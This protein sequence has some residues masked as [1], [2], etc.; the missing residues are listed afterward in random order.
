[1]NAE[2]LTAL[3]SNCTDP[4]IDER[5]DGNLLLQMSYNT[6][7][8]K[9]V[10]ELQ[11]EL[12]SRV[13]IIDKDQVNEARNHPCLFVDDPASL[14]KSHWQIPV[15]EIPEEKTYAKPTLYDQEKTD[16]KE[17]RNLP[18]GMGATN[19]ECC[20]KKWRSNEPGYMVDSQDFV[21]WICDKLQDDEVDEIL[22]ALGDQTELIACSYCVKLITGKDIEF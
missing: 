14:F 3:E 9:V 13:A 10:L 15:E 7:M 11:T 2:V 17:K 1:M 21:S 19:C 12:E 16:L 22:E 20:G 18:F 8:D 4:F 5:R 6:K